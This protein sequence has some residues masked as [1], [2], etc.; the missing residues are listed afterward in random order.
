MI[1][2]CNQVTSA[3]QPTSSN[4]FVDYTWTMTGTAGTTTIT[5]TNEAQTVVTVTVALPASTWTFSSGGNP[6][7]N[8]SP[9]PYCY[10][11]SPD[12]TTVYVTASQ[13]DSFAIPIPSLP[14]YPSGNFPFS[15]SNLGSCVFAIMASHHIHLTLGG[16]YDIDLTR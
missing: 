15:Y 12:G 11:V 5:E 2:S 10:A 3:S 1:T 13:N 9:L 4:P 14:N 7:V 8:S 6:A 16:E